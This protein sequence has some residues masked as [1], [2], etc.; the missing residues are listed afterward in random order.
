MFDELIALP[1]GTSYNSY[2]IK[3]SKKT[4]LIDTVDP[5]KSKELIFNLRDVKK[6]DYIISNHAEQDHSGTIP[7][8]LKKYP[9]AKLVC[10]SLCKKIL[11]DELTIDKKRII[12][13]K[14]QEEISL[15]DKTLKFIFT[16]WVHW[17][18]TMSTFVKEDKILFSCDFFG[19]HLATEKLFVEDNRKVYLPAKR[20]YA[21]IM[22]PFR[23]II[24]KNLEKVR[25]L[26]PKIIA[27][28]HGQI[29]K[30]PDWIIKQYQEWSE[31]KPKPLIVVG[32]TSM[33]GSTKK[34]V[35]HLTKKL[36]S[37]GNNVKEFNLTETEIGELAIE[38]VDASTLIVASPTFL[39]GL[40]PIVSTKINTLDKLKPK[41]KILGFIGSKEWGGE[42]FEEFK[43][44]TNNFEAETILGEIATGIPKKHNYKKLND[45]SKT[46]TEKTKEI[47]YLKKTEVVKTNKKT[48]VSIV[49]AGEAG[50]GLVAIQNFLLKTLKIEGYYFSST[51]EYMS[52]V[53]GGVNTVSI[54][55]TSTPNR[56]NLKKIDVLL[57]LDKNTLTENLK[58][59][60]D[61]DTI[62]IGDLKEIRKEGL[63][64]KSINLSFKEMAENIGNKL[65]ANTVATGLILGM[66]EIKKNN[67]EK[68]L[69]ENFL[70]KGKKITL[71]NIEASKK[72]YLTAKE[73]L[74]KELK[75]I[76]EIKLKKNKAELLLTGAQT[77]A[78]GA[79]SG[80]CNFIS[81]YPMSPSTGVLQNLA[82]QRDNFD[83]IV[84]QAEDE[85][86]A[87]NMCLGASFAGA[88]A[89]ANT[90][91][92]G[93]S[94]MCE[95]VSL[96]GM[97][98]TP[99]VIHIAQ[100]PGP[101][102]GLPTRTAQEDL[103][104]VIYS[105]H[106]EFTRIVYA[107]KD[108]KRGFEITHLSFNQAS[109]Y[110]IP[111]FI[112]TDQY[113]MENLYPIQKIDANNYK[114]ENH[115]VKSKEDYNRYQLTEDGISPRAIPGNG[116]GLVCVDSDEHDVTGHITED[117]KIREKM[118]LKRLKRKE[119]ITYN[120]LKPTI[121][122]D[123]SEYLVIG[124]GSTFETIKEA[125]EKI[126]NNKIR[127]IHFEQIYPLHPDTKE[128][129]ESAKKTM[130]IEGNAT[131]QFSELIK[132]ETGKDTEKILKYN[133][134]QFYV[135]EVV[136]E[137]TKRL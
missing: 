106:G 97:I 44:I 118:V 114:I 84:E 100:R 131:G 87:I 73:L 92:G 74:K 12:V 130:V 86:A 1:D 41:T 88:R 6:I 51:S 46:I 53:R 115:I 129:I 116:K 33:H 77:I 93:F 48:E 38:M 57:L 24:L 113:F 89:L 29:Y 13:I 81:A 22:M 80:G 105:G 39:G 124:W 127:Y 78:Y 61:K 76:K 7:L 59:R 109:K 79:I 19:A 10:N 56:G 20:Y 110:Q 32:Y 136:Q 64:N 71:K 126:N 36:R 35:E 68:I 52:R 21:E 25:K 60:I 96:S 70:K 111:V 23:K 99:L 18:E 55:V 75:K 102:T 14:D 65:Y 66:L 122:G 4:A 11:L 43:K 42:S 63:K 62:I 3:G 47:F 134:L 9:K 31:D 30:D 104:L 120:C 45:F 94:L 34:M 37:Q 15:G 2:L 119:E 101:A 82:K 95:G 135:E 137:I 125:L 85:I 54:R 28:S 133:G 26:K 40:H 17:P 16:P 72:G 112:L 132:K 27:P 67:F 49:L 128:W 117:F 83:I 123:G 8:I 103:N 90:S 98:E 69:K 50:Q 5:S 108:L 121:I 91:G 107:P 58:E